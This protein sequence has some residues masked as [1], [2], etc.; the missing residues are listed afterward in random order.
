MPL[1]ITARILVEHAGFIDTFQEEGFKSLVGAWPEINDLEKSAFMW[2]SNMYEYPKRLSRVNSS[3]RNFRK[4][5][6]A[7]KL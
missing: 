3:V 6:A 2:A 4:W 7:I 1:R 5:L